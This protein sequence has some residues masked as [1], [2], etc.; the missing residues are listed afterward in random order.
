MSG[1]ETGADGR[2]N[3]VVTDDGQLPVDIVVLGL[4]VR[5]ATEL[6]RAAGLPLGEAGGVLTDRRMRVS[7]HD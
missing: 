7:D 3:A 5:P 4:G 6:A 1:F 2:V